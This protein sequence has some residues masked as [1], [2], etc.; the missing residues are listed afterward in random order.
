MLGTRLR[1]VLRRSMVVARGRGG[2]HGIDVQDA[3]GLDEATGGGGVD[4][5]FADAGD[6]VDC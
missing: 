1:G 6:T 5:C 2:A 4:T 3:D